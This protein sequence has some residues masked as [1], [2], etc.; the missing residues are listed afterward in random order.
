MVTGSGCTQGITQEA[1]TAKI[2]APGCP[3]S[4]FD[5]ASEGI[6]SKLVKRLQ[7]LHCSFVIQF[8]SV[9]VATIKALKV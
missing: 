6:L 5:G 3:Y 1:E 7:E 9:V 8:V 2:D 4:S